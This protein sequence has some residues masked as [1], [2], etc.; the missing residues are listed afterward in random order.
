MY[1]AII[2]G[3]GV[4]GCAIARELSRYQLNIL[5][6]EKEEDVCCGTSKAN[7]AIIHAGHDAKPGSLKARFNVRGNELM[8]QLSADL[9][10]PFTRNGSLVLC[11]EESQI[12][13]L[14]ELADRGRKNGVPG[15][16]IVTG[17]E[18]KSLEP[19]LHSVTSFIHSSRERP[20]ARL[21][22][23]M[24]PPCVVNFYLLSTEWS[25]NLFPIIIMDYKIA[26]EKLPRN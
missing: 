1:D 3:A 18:I 4:T 25:K 24:K 19:A 15:L 22:A 16:S 9:N 8:D 6:L 10:F 21:S 5:V 17:E 11:F 2:I 7:S 14:E 20:G 23:I 13:E 26:S 12:P